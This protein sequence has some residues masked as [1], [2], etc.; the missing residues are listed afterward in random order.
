MKAEK[1]TK[2]NRKKPEKTSILNRIYNLNKS[3]NSAGHFMS[4]AAL[5]VLTLFVLVT[6]GGC[7]ANQASDD[8][9]R[10]KTQITMWHYYSGTQKSA[11]DSMVNEFNETVGL[12]EGIVVNPMAMGSIADLNTAVMNSAEEKVGAELMPDMFTT[13]IDTAM[14]IDE[15]GKLASLDSYFTDEELDMY[16]PEYI[17][18]G[19]FDSE[20]NLKVF[21]VAKATEIMMINKTQWDRFADETGTDVSLLSTW[22][23][24]TQVSEKYY[25]WSGGK[26]FFGRDAMANYVLT[27]SMELGQEIFEVNGKEVKCNFDRDI[28]KR[29]WQNYYLPYIKGYFYKEGRYASDDL[30]VGSIAAY[31]GSTSSA[32]YFPANVYPDGDES[33]TPIE[34]MLLPVPEFEGVDKP[35]VVQQG[36][37][38]AVTI[39]D[40]KKQEACARFLKWFTQSERNT[41]FSVSASY[42]PVTKEANNI[43]YLRKVAKDREMEIPDTVLDTMEISIEQIGKSA[44]YTTRAF[45]KG[46]DARTILENT[47]KNKAMEDK[48]EIDKMV[49]SGTPFEKAAASF[50]SEESFQ[51]WYDDT[52]ASIMELLGEN[53]P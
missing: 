30:K 2:D 39:S 45:D 49:E 24:L 47:L 13:Y 22:E 14:Q 25:E 40:E 18:E 31:V 7:S 11:F 28:M 35:V 34:C 21:P 4:G 33:A 46:Y 27:G 44:L 20:G 29:I 36:A 53:T 50:E 52:Y 16:I 17:E 6:T 48:A 42:L 5:A 23:G 15:M 51:A 8:V 43:E 38:Y 19:R 3:G 10:E 37:G 12:E 41:Y 26:A 1:Y 32:A 9:K